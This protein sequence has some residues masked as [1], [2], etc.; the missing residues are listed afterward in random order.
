[1]TL[2]VFSALAGCSKSGEEDDGQD[3]SEV[4][5]VSL[6]VTDI[7]DDQATINVALTEGNFYGAKFI[8]AVRSNTVS[9]DYSNEIKLINYV[10]ENGV[11]VDLPYTN[12]ITGLRNGNEMFSAVIV[13]NSKGIAVNSSCQVWTAVGE[14]WNWS[15]ENEAGDLEEI[16]WTDNGSGSGGVDP[17]DGNEPDNPDNQENSG[18]EI[19]GSAGNL[20]EILWPES[21]GSSSG[22]QEEDNGGNEPAA[23][24]DPGGTAGNLGEIIW[25]L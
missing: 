7:A 6:E 3:D 23:N 11:D 12:T 10:K 9:V 25:D 14:I 2:A 8:E 15:G 24:S 20:D 13:F 19:G 22:N 5:R 21:G 18:S 1:M 17:G 4:I 16:D